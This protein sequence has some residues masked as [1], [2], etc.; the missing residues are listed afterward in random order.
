MPSIL[1][2]GGFVDV[3]GRKSNCDGHVAAKN[4]SKF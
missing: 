4:A 1:L 3:N 2:A